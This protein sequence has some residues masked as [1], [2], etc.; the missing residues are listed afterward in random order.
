MKKVFYLSGPPGAGKTSVANELAALLGDVPVVEVDTIKCERH[1][2]TECSTADDFREA[3]RRT[4][5][6]LESTSRAIIVEAFF[7]DRYVALVNQELPRDIS[8][9]VFLLWCPLSIA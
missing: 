3:G 9:V 2:T 1:G 4:A 7:D 5:K 8:K 6:A